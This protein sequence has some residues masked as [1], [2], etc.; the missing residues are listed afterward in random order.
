M[1]EHLPP[2]DLIRRAYAAFNAR[3]LDS[4]LSALHRDVDWL[5]AIDGGRVRGHDE[6]RH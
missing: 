2:V 5:N 1:A 6:V 4:A 3:D